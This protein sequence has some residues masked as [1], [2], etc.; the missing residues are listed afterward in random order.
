MRVAAPLFVFAAFLCGNAAAETNSYGQYASFK[1][2]MFYKDGRPNNCW[3]DLGVWEDETRMFFFPDWQR[4]LPAIL[5]MNTSWSLSRSTTGSVVI[6]SGGFESRYRI[7]RSSETSIKIYI[8]NIDKF[9]RAFTGNYSM[10]FK[11]PK[12][13]WN[14]D[15]VGS[16][17]AFQ[18]WRRCMEDLIEAGTSYSEN[19]WSNEQTSDN[20]WR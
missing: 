11:A 7:K 17:D 4:E 6:E 3:I 2:Q 15:L 13:G 16:Y 12:G 14:L 20:P 18:A 10:N 1:V 5:M 19:P 9:E 8:D